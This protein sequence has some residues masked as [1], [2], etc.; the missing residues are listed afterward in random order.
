MQAIT[1]I[2]TPVKN[3][4]KLPNPALKDDLSS[5]PVIISPITAPRNGITIR[6]MGAKKMPAITPIPAPHIPALEPPN[7]FAPHIGTI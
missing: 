5:R 2:S 7:F 6:P 4:I 3:P 1:F